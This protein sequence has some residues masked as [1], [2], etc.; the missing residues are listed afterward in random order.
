MGRLLHGVNKWE[1]ELR[2]S[3]LES[4]ESRDGTEDA[5]DLEWDCSVSK[6]TA[7]ARIATINK[8]EHWQDS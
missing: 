2:V 8:I 5:E 1:H 7:T 6:V 4:F 3:N